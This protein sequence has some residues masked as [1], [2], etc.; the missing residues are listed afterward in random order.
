[1]SKPIITYI[2]GFVRAYFAHDKKN[3]KIPLNYYY[4]VHMYMSA[5][6]KNFKKKEKIFF[7]RYDR[8]HFP[9]AYINRNRIWCAGKFFFARKNL[10]S[11][12]ISLQPV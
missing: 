5:D 10:R 8:V 9:I 11:H 7:D 1:M 4:Y 6:F 12:Q 2:F 3:A